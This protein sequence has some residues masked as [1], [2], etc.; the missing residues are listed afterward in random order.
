MCV[1]YTAKHQQVELFA[2]SLH[3]TGEIQ[4]KLP[5]AGSMV[6]MN[7]DSADR[8]IWAS[9]KAQLV[10]DAGTCC[11]ASL[12]TAFKRACCMSMLHLLSSSCASTHIVSLPSA[13]SMTTC[14]LPNVPHHTLLMLCTRTRRRIC[15][16]TATENK[17]ALLTLT[18]NMHG[19]C[20]IVLAHVASVHVP[21]SC[22][23]IAVHEQRA[24]QFGPVQVSSS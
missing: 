6:Q 14:T 11:D 3:V 17:P 15:H 2:H 21:E 13:A 24:V 8:N 16:L 23:F 10:P 19:T 4:W 18:P 7:G 12:C 5:T 9:C 20:P 22:P 1:H